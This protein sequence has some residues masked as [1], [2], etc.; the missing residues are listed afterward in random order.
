MIKDALI[1]AYRMDPD[2]RVEIWRVDERSDQFTLT[3]PI[4]IGIQGPMKGLTPERERQINERSSRLTAQPITERRAQMI[5]GTG[6]GFTPGVTPEKVKQIDELYYKMAAE[7]QGWHRDSDEYRK[8]KEAVAAVHD[9]AGTYD[10]TD[11]DAKKAMEALFA[12]LEEKAKAYADKEAYKS[13]STERGVTRKNTALSI[14]DTIDGGVEGN[15]VDLR[16]KKG[17]A[18]GTHRTFRDLMKAEKEATSKTYGTQAEA[19]RK[20]RRKKAEAEKAAKAKKADPVRKAD[21]IA[22]GKKD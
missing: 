21:P 16:Q 4:S 12:D 5:T 8:M 9:A 15:V 11:P 1:T 19:A 10:P 18:K 13:K 22:P 6:A 7:K 20:A 17:E 2:S 3:D 14:L